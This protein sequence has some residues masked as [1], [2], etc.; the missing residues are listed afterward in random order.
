MAV[1]GRDT[2]ICGDRNFATF[3]M[4]KRDQHDLGEEFG[5]TSVKVGACILRS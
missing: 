4:L 1:Y 5:D 2:W 3:G